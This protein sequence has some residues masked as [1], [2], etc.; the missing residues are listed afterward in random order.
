MM[1]GGVTVYTALKRAG[2]KFNDW[3]LIVGSGGGLGHLAIQYAKALGARVLGLDTSSKA[4][5]CE[6]LGCDAFLDFT[7]YSPADLTSKIK[8][9]TGG[10][11]RI[12]LQCSS[13]VKAYAQA[14]DWLGFRGTLVC[15]GVPEGEEEPI[16]GAKV[17]PM[18]GLELTIFAIKSGNRLDAK[19]CLEIAAR[20]LVKTQ[21]QLRKMEELTNV[22]TEMEEGKI[23]GRVVLDLR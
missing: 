12:V 1:C 10:G 23:N 15:L 11:A 3:V 19:E 14:V 5:F 8:E 6:S 17:G 21:F 13:S 20:G 16:G 9:I 7:S 18:I 22:F 2:V 4:A